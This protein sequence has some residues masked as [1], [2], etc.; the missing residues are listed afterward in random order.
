MI[1]LKKSS[2]ILLALIL[3]S[4][5]LA[6]H[7]DA[8][9]EFRAAAIIDKSAS[10]IGAIQKDAALEP[11][12]KA[13]QIEQRKA[14]VDGLVD[15]FPDSPDV[16]SSGARASLQEGEVAAA[17]TRAGLA[18]AL[19]R[20]KTPKQLAEALKTQAISFVAG[21][22]YPRAFEAAQEALRLFP[23][24]RNAM[25]LVGLTRERGAKKAAAR[26][27]SIIAGAQAGPDTP[28]EVSGRPNG[29]LQNLLDAARDSYADSVEETKKAETDLK[30]GDYQAM[31]D[32]AS[33]AIKAM[34]DNPKAYMQRAF[35]GLMLKSYDDVVEDATRGL[36]LAPRSAALLGLRAAAYNETARP[37]LAWPD[38]ENAVAAD[39]RDAFAVLQRGLAAE[40]LGKPDEQSLADIRK[41][42]ELDPSFAHFYTEALA[43]RGQ[44][45]AF[46]QKPAADLAPS[47]P[48]ASRRPA[49]LAGLCSL[50]ICAGIYLLLGRLWK[51]ERPRPARD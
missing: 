28:A 42:G 13:A 50:L 7:P 18:V 26:A 41:A 33:A 9:N 32:Q 37:Q 15:K 16:Q 43:R 51:D 12:E 23:Q 45:P 29:A 11:R 10:E 46:G 17:L 25:I 48:T 47:Y 35:A 20:H 1:A 19:A 27:A 38:A 6:L 8:F 36:A 2:T 34:P 22:D 21:G 3:P 4:A 40:R 24:D 5:A 14:Q 44:A 39:P 30:L 49:A 31:R